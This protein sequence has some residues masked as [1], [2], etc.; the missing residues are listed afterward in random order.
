M[1]MPRMGSARTAPTGLSC[2]AT[3]CTADRRLHAIAERRALC[4][5]PLGSDA[6]G[7]LGRN[8]QRCRYRLIIEV[9]CHSRESGNLNQPRTS[10]QQVPACAGMTAGRGWQRDTAI[11]KRPDKSPDVGFPEAAKSP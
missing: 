10:L 8:I 5:L 4:F 3:Q 6:G 11:K 2:I 1:P 7:V 9:T